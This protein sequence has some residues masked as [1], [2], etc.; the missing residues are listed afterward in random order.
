MAW[1]TVSLDEVRGTEE[2]Y[3]K[4][5]VEPIRKVSEF[6]DYVLGELLGSLGV[7]CSRPP[8][9]IALQQQQLDIVV[10]EL[11]TPEDVGKLCE[12]GGLGFNPAVMG[13]Y[14]F[15]H[16]EPKYFIPNPKI[17]AGKVIIEFYCFDTNQ[18]V[19]TGTLKV[20]LR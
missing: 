5:H 11:D 20:P 9:M 13:Y 2:Q 18:M 7:D 19:E 10:T 12:A 14:I 1:Y 16:Y 3:Q 17:K 8:A 15:Q 4:Q 6:V